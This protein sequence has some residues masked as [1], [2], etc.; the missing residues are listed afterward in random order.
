[1][2]KCVLK[3][4]DLLLQSAARNEPVDM[5]ATLGKMTLAVMGECAFG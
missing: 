1:M 5:F 2:E 4:R 3:M